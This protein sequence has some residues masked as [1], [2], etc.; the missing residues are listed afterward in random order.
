MSQFDPAY[1]WAGTSTVYS[2][3]N[4]GTNWTTT[5]LTAPAGFVT[6]ITSDPTN[7]DKVFVATAGV[8]ATKKHFFLSTD[9]GKTFTSPA[10]N[11]PDVPCWS[12]AFN[13][14]DNKIFVGT[15]KGVV[16]S[17]DGGVTWNPVMNGMPFV[18][19]MSLKIKGSQ[20]NILLAGT[21][22]R[23]IFSLDI[24]TLDVKQSLTGKSSLQLD[25]IQ[26]NPV[27]GSEAR[28]NFT[29][30]TPGVVQTTLYD[31]LGREVRILDKNFYDAG[32]HSVSFSASGLTKGTYVVGL[33]SNGK[34]VSQKVIIE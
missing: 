24:T 6:A 4:Q 3:T 13:P 16:Y 18:Q 23:G 8:G 2:S 26:P 28:M 34:A 32:S 11:F 21:Y 15:D 33:I 19:V 12:I 5:S 14:T 1:M 9:G 27:T 17:E 22:G 31:M 10:T 20:N 7:K 30:P 29:L 25:P